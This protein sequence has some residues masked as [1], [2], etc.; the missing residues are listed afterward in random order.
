MGNPSREDP[1]PPEWR[2]LTAAMTLVKDDRR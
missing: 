2:A 1:A